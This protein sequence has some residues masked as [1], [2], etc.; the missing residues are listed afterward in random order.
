[1]RLILVATSPA[2]YQRISSDTRLNAIHE[3]VIF[4][5]R[6]PSHLNCHGW[7]TTD[8]SPSIDHRGNGGPPSRNSILII[9]IAL[10]DTRAFA[11]SEPTGTRLGRSGGCPFN[12]SPFVILRS[13]ATRT[14]NADN[15]GTPVARSRRETPGFPCKTT[16]SSVIFVRRTR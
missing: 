5:A 9:F 13:P 2:I 15:S 14:L 12:A 3:H 1:M 16:D 8:G 4:H 6:P 10:W 7:N 11:P